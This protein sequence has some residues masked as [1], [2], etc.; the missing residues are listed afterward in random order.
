MKL[1]DFLKKSSNSLILA[2]IMLPVSEMKE[3][4]LEKY[5]KIKPNNVSFSKEGLQIAVK[6]SASPIFYSFGKNI[7]IKKIKAQ[8]TFFGLPIFSP[9]KAKNS[10]DSEDL[11]LRIGLI[12]NGD[13]KLTGFKKFFV[14]DWVKHLYEQVPTEMGLDHVY[15]FNLVQDKNLVGTIKIHSNSDLIKEEYI[16]HISEAGQFKIDYSLKS[17]MLAFATW[18]G[19]D[20]DDTNSEFSVLISQLEFEYDE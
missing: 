2:A 14:P 7:K 16:Q 13:K 17:P 15:F 18:L 12:V 11:P 6:N 19:A 5:A 9:E 8:G 20:G 10:K 4:K 1:F 3:W